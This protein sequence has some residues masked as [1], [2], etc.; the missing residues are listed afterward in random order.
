LGFAANLFF[1]VFA[2]VGTFL[3][4]ADPNDALALAYNALFSYN[5]RILTASFIAYI[6]GSLLNAASLIWIKKLTG[7]KWLFARTI[8]STA[9]GALADTVIFTV[10]AW[11]FTLGVR[12]IF[13]MIL[14]GYAVKMVFEVVIATPFD[15]FAAP[16]IKKLVEKEE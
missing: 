7:D 8:G 9:L 15:Y 16:R 5:I 3:P 2:L 12:E 4:S 14:S 6:V 10:I 13:I 1:A 11:A